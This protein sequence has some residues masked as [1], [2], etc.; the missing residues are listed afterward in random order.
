MKLVTLG[1]TKMK[2]F[3]FILI[4]AIVLTLLN[5]NKSDTVDL[6]SL[7]TY[8]YVAIPLVSAEIDIQDMLERDTGGVVSTGN[9]GELFLAYTTPPMSMS[10]S[11]VITLSDESFDIDIP[12]GLY[13]V[14]QLGFHLQ[15]QLLYKILPLTILC[16]PMG[17]RIDFH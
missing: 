5:C 9:Q 1:T 2:K 15:E 16:F 4:S 8:H 7:Q 17:R 14:F 11:E 10:A 6:S 13:L 3:K 12:L